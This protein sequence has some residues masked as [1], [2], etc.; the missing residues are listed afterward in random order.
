MIILAIGDVVGR[1]GRKILKEMLPKIKRDNNIDICI[2]NGE[3]SATGN[4][5]TSKITKEL[6]SYGVD[7]ITLGNHAY[8]KKEI[9]EYIDNEDSLIRPANFPSDYPGK[10]STIFYKG[11]IKVGVIN[12]CGKVYFDRPEITLDCPFSIAEKEIEKLKEYTNVILVDIHAEATS[13][14]L[15]LGWY[16]DGKVSAVFGTH[17]HVQTADERILPN[18]TGI[19]TDIGMTGPYNSV[20]GIETQMVINRFLNI[21]P[22]KFVISQGDMQLNGV[23]F[24]IDKVSGKCTKIER[25]RY[26]MKE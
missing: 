18:G 10:G 19:I 4:G 8:A 16:L 11:N 13:E 5:I 23:M 20:L 6:F 26:F 7:I 22:A 3:N 24:E 14:K 21:E 17:T 9:N 1:P 2:V 12:L 25:I 15:A